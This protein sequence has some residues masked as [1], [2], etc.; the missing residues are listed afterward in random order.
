MNNKKMEPAFQKF[1]IYQQGLAQFT[2]DILKKIITYK[3]KF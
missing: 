3:E 1:V 2:C